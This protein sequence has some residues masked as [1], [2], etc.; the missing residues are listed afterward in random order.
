M[1]ITICGSIKFTENMSQISGQLL[2][3]GHETELPL[4][5]IKILS[6]ELTL[7]EFERESE[8]E[9]RKIQDDVIR[10]YYEKIKESE[11]ILVANYDKNGIR[12]YIGGNTFLEIGFAYVLNKKIFLFNE[13]PEIGYSD[14][15]KAMQPVILGG[16]L[17]KIY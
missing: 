11:A 13:I 9:N 5:S 3:N 17:S 4:T 8:G 15:I 1:K 7:E 12:N 14:E 6:G 10:K 16:D 2:K